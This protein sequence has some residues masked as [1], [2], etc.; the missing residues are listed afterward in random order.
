TVR[1]AHDRPGGVTT[2]RWSAAACASLSNVYRG[3]I[4]AR[5]LGSRGQSPY[6]QTC[7]ESGDAAGDGPTLSTDPSAPASGMAFYYL[8]TTENPGSES[9]L[10]T[11]PGGAP[12]PNNS[13][14]PTPPP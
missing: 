8:V 7:F 12:I 4:P 1:P 9:S 5:L 6:D 10:G 2:L 3:T 11:G 13:P 14:C